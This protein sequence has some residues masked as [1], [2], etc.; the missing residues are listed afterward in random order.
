[1]YVRTSLNW[2]NMCMYIHTYVMHICKSYLK[3]SSNIIHY[4]YCVG[5]GIYVRM[6]AGILRTYVKYVR[7]YI[8]LQ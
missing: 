2:L 8:Q 7:S 6:Y 4:V 3:I 1:M 5:M